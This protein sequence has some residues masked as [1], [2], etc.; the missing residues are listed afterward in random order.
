MALFNGRECSLSDPKTRMPA[1]SMAT[2]TENM[3]II[4]RGRGS[5][6]ILSTHRFHARINDRAK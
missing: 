2:G 5:V 4:A 1:S 3:G 6:V